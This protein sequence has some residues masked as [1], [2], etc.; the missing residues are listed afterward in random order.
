VPPTLRPD[1]EDGV[2]DA[3]AGA[4]ADAAP[5]ALEGA[6]PGSVT[7]ARFVAHEDVLG[8]DAVIYDWLVA[9]H[10][11]GVHVSI[12]YPCDAGPNKRLQRFWYAL[13]PEYPIGADGDLEIRAIDVPIAAGEGLLVA[14]DRHQL[15]A[16]GG[17]VRGSERGD[18][19]ERAR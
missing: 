11:E 16:L 19:G 3:I 2:R 13:L 10:P 14:G 5:L 4:L 9:N 1:D 15:V 18:R 6:E 17:R 12:P 8:K 7:H